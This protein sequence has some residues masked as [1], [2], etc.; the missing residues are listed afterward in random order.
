MGE[1]YVERWELGGST[2][3]V[4]C[5]F[6]DVFPEE[7]P[8]LPPDRDVEFKID[9]ILGTA[10]VSRRPYR[11][12]PD[13]LKELKT[14]LQEQLD[15]GFIRPS[16]SPWGC[17]ALF[18][19]KKDQGG[20]RLC[21]DYRPLN[22]VTVKNKYPL[23]HIDILLLSN[24][25]QGRRYTQNSL[26]HQIR[27]VRI[28]S[29]VFGLTNA[30]AFFMY[31]MNSVFMNE[32][33]KF[34]V[35]FIDDILVYSKNEEEHEEHLRTVLTRLRE[36]QLYAKF[37][38]CAFWLREATSCP[39]KGVA[40]D[41]SKVEDV[42]NWKQPET[43]FLGL[44]GYYRRFIKDFSKTAKPMTSLT[45]KK[46]KY[47]WSPN[48]EEAF[49][50]LKRSLTTAP[51]LAQPDVTKPF[52][53]YCDAFGNGLGCVLMQEGRVVTYASHQL[54]KHEA[55]YLTHDLE[56]AAVVYALKIWRHYLLGNTCH[57]YTDHKSLKYILTQP[58]LNMR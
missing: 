49:Q 50:S 34:I 6:P 3:P 15:K 46:S 37:S 55:N 10:P 11:M 24:K 48:C 13:E 57:L 5:E 54:R 19:E 9:L 14:Q 40:V 39:K 4:V 35:V 26:L 38:K 52:D 18:V 53:V 31:M 36:H 32:L 29:H 58:E 44:A 1:A 28:S 22:A 7:F 20:K 23:P 16:S 8:G 51:V 30:P 33:D 41:P 43:S 12:A 45:K 25:N 2:T 56:L 42:L 21:L 47:S 17:P 27:L